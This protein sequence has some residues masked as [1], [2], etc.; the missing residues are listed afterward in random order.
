MRTGLVLSLLICASVSFVSAQ[1]T[2]NST[3]MVPSGKG[4]AIPGKVPPDI[5]NQGNGIDY[6][7]G[8]IMPGTPNVYLIWYGNWK[9]G[10]APSDSPAT[11]SLVTNFFR[12]NSG[13]PY[14]LIN[15]TYGD[16]NRDVTGLV[17]VGASAKALTYPLGKSLSDGSIVQIVTKVISAGMLPKDVNGI[18]FVMTTSDVNE[19]SGFCA[20]YCGWHNHT[21]I[22]GTDI[23]YGFIGNSDRCPNTCEAQTVSPNNNSGADGMINTAAGELVEAISDPDLNAWWSLQ[24]GFENADQCAWKFGTLLGGSIGNGGYNQTM[25][26]V[27]YLVQMN[28]E[29]ARGGGCD[30]FLGGPFLNN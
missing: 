10:P 6:H 5:V 7:G 23:K 27:N 19:T 30:N 4:F 3:A 26:G 13:S 14:G 18:Y 8:S 16:T 15:S 28:W 17:N 9:A 25:N 29:N 1:V 11:V 2:R 20:S 22:A 24:T 12:N 21:S